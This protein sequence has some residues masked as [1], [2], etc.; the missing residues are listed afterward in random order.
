M[1]LSPLSVIPPTVIVCES[2]GPCAA[3]FGSELT[4]TLPALDLQKGVPLHALLTGR[5]WFCWE[6]AGKLTLLELGFAHTLFASFI[7]LSQILRLFL[8]PFWSFDQSRMSLPLSFLK[9]AEFW[10]SVND[11]CITV[12]NHIVF[13]GFNWLWMRI[14]E[15]DVRSCVCFVFVMQ[16]ISSEEIKTLTTNF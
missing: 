16:L 15:F 11:G 1:S 6:G 12:Q 5:Q 7:V 10:G 13:I 9:L 3:V 2:S 4:S 8:I 14:S